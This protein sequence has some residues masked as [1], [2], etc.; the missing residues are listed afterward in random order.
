MLNQETPQRASKA[1][2]KSPKDVR[3]QLED[4]Y[5]SHSN[6]PVS[7]QVFYSR[8]QYLGWDV[9]SALTTPIVK[10][11]SSRPR[12]EIRQFYDDNV[13]RAQ[14]NL[15]VYNGRVR[16]GGWDREKALTTPMTDRA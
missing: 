7:Y 11:F 14:V 2:F 12:G 15:N 6:P 3:E 10:E 4:I 9:I 16:M 5:A 13:S 8:A 1:A